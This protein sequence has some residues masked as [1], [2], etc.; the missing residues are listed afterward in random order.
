[1]ARKNHVFRHKR[2][3]FRKLPFGTAFWLA[4]NTTVAPFVKI[5]RTGYASGWNAD[6]SLNETAVS[7]ST[8]A[9]VYVPDK[10]LA[11]NRILN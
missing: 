3:N 9:V 1:M 7:D 11:Q 10:F 4:S 8:V 6:G 2:T 5:S